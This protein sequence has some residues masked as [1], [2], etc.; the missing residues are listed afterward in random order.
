MLVVSDYREVVVAGVRYATPCTWQ[1]VT[2][3]RFLVAT[4]HTALLQSQSVSS[5]NV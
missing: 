3:H 5:S 1:F 4:L 2:S